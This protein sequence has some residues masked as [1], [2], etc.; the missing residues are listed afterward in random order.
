MSIDKIIREMFDTGKSGKIT[1]K[2]GI[3]IIGERVSKTGC[4]NT[5]AYM[6]AVVSTDQN[7]VSIELPPKEG[8][9]RGYTVRLPKK[10]IKEIQYN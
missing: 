7:Y 2:P 4:A 5:N 6:A 9:I 8:D 3:E 1:L 10:N